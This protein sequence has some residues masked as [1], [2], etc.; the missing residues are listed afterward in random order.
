MID[1]WSKSGKKGYAARRCQSI[2]DRMEQM[3]LEGELYIKPNS[4]TYNAVLNAWSKSGEKDSSMNAEMILKRMIKYQTQPDVFTYTTV[5]DTLK[6]GGRY[7]A[8]RALEILKQMQTENIVK[9]NTYTYTTI[10]NVL[11]KSG[12]YDSGD[13]CIALLDYMMELYKNYNDIESKPNIVTCNGVLLAI[14]RAKGIHNASKIED[15]LQRMKLPMEQNGFHIPPDNISYNIAI[16]YYCWKNISTL[17]SISRA[18]SLLQEMKDNQIQPTLNQYNVIIIALSKIH[19]H[20][21]AKMADSLLQQMI[22]ESIILPDTV[23]FNACM[24]SYARNRGLAPAHRVEELI[25][26]MYT[27]HKSGTHPDLKPNLRSFAAVLQ[28]WARSGLREKA[29]IRA[30][31]IIHRMEMLYEEGE[32][33]SP[34]D[35][36]W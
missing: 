5:I 8:F 28:T 26:Q 35:V 3:Y 20:K 13:T 29:A 7:S 30:E 2:L 17:D 21:S 14:S 34:P 25:T 15:L 1:A 9:P 11:A 18:I 23:T 22:Q 6:G 16:L 33:D 36:Y 10:I 27:L 12:D 24:S 32:L 31:E 19:H 4:Y